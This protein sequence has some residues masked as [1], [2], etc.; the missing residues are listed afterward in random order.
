MSSVSIIFHGVIE[1]QIT[2]FGE[3]SIVSGFADVREMFEITLAGVGC[4]NDYKMISG[5]RDYKE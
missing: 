1:V 5:Q 2:S 3:Q 4:I